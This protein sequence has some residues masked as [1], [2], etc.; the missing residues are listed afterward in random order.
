[1]KKMRTI[2]A[3][4]IA[5]IYVI[6]LLA[7]S[8]PAHAASGTL[9][10]DQAIYPVWGI[11]GSVEVTAENLETNVT[12]SLW[13]Q[14]P[15]SVLS[16]PVGTPFV[17]V[18]GTTQ[19]PIAIAISTADP[20]GTYTLSLSKSAASDTTEAV[21]HFG[22]TGTDASSYERTKIVI[23]AGGGFASNSSLTLDVRLGNRSVS[24][25]PTTV[26]TQ[27]NGEFTYA[28]RLPPSAVI[29]TLNASVAGRTL[30]A[31]QLNSVSS[32]FTVGPTTFS[33]QTLSPPTKQV[34]RTAQVN[35]TYRLSYPDHSPVSAINATADIVTSGHRVSS[36]S[37]LLVNSTTGEWRATWESPPSANVTAYHFQVDP[38]TLTDAYGN[39][40]QGSPVTSSDFKVVAAKLHLTIQTEPTLQRTQTITATMAATY[41][42]G[43]EA[44]NVTHANVIITRTDSARITL[45]AAVNGSLV[46][47]RYAIPVNASIGN[48]T[49][50]YDAQDLWG[51]SGSGI[52]IVQVQLASPTF[53][54]LTPQTTERT[55][56]L[57][58][59]SKMSYPDGTPMNSTA[60]LLISHGNLTW[61]PELSFNATTFVWA[62]SLYI[63]QNATLGPYNV[64]WAT[65]DSYGNAG[66]NTSISTIIPARFRFSP[67]SNNSTMTAFSNLDLNMTVRYPNGT[68]LTNGFGNVTG[69]YTNSSGSVLTLPLAYNDT[70]HA[71]HMYFPVPEQGNLTFSF[72]AIDRFGNQGVAADAYNLKVIPSQ[73]VQ[74]QRLIIAGIVGALIP[75]ALLIWAVATISTRRRKH[76]P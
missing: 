6:C 49:V 20:P 3:F 40:G 69:A 51:N 52:F 19:S 22:V 26:V 14:K 68:T 41:H 2:L 11:G 43:A 46:P 56:F 53:Q 72:S 75:I 33:V 66:N 54:L 12:Y 17:G 76:R 65:H 64:S 27:S 60:T 8:H 16:Y 38:T 15:K 37:L 39:K 30:D 24:G 10:T 1:M 23:V 7:N 36:V 63:V 5:F 44:A 48:W 58:V 18:N 34:E 31:H 47:A 35:A 74:T 62:G 28:F 42:N 21:A 13:L 29:G 32:F 61:S 50:S 45:R 57:N 4:L 9:R 67:P 71:W 55:T 73:R 59:T 70:E 25:F